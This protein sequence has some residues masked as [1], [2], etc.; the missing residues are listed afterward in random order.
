MWLL[1]IRFL[2]WLAGKLVPVLFAVLVVVAGAALFLF[3]RD[4]LDLE[5]DRTKQL[6]ALAV[7]E[8]RLQVV[9]QE[10][11]AR[12]HDLREQYAQAQTRYHQAERLIA[13]LEALR[14]FWDNLFRSRKERDEEQTRLIWAQQK[15]KEITWSLEDLNA[16]LK[17]A[18]AHLERL[19]HHMAELHR[20]REELERAESEVLNYAQKA[21]IVVKAPLLFGIAAYLFAPS[22]WKVFCYYAWAP[23]IGLGRPIVLN[24]GGLVPLQA[25][26]SQVS[27]RIPVKP[28]E[29]AVLKEKFLQA[30]DEGLR[31]RT[32]FVFDW[33]MPFSSA[34]CGLI[35]LIEML[36]PNEDRSYSITFST[37]EDPAMELSDIEL[38]EGSSL[39]LRPSYLAGVVKGVDERLRIERHWRFFS[40]HAWVTLQFRYFEFHGPCRLIVCGKRGVRA[41]QMQ[42]ASGE[43]AASRRTNQDST[44]GFTPN[45]YYHSARA[46]TFWAYYRG[47]N[48][49]FDDLFRGSAGVFLCQ[50]ITSRERAH[51]VRQFW[52]NFWGGLLKIFGL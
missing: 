52:A 9:R 35:E 11:E 15:Q 34:A 45:L 3:A 20:E 40:V 17:A 51:S 47:R 18:S 19:D 43:P 21:W 28:G 39:V 2:S 8:E 5:V 29:K 46:E 50:E 6:E 30:S 27:K 38:P 7:K 23:L 32:R 36:N 48:P 24:E 4:R 42:N 31:R 44:I 1:T 33:R 13:N 49:L 14:S 10:T 12:W 22:F 25:A 37:Q 26:T 41:E 16:Q